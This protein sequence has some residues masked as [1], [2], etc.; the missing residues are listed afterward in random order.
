MILCTQ[1]STLCIQRAGAT[2]AFCLANYSTGTTTNP[3]LPA[4]KV[5]NNY[6]PTPKYA[7]MYVA[8]YVFVIKYK[9]WFPSMFTWLKRNSSTWRQN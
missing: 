8:T 5:H 7:Y 9:Q 6:I 1:S 4:G 2:I 3:L